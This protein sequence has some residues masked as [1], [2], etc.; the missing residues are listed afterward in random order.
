MP[1]RNVVSTLQDDGQEVMGPDV[2][3]YHHPGNDVQ[4][5]T[6]LTVESNHFCVL[7]SR[8][9]ARADDLL[10]RQRA[11]S[12]VGHAAEALR[13]LASG[14]RRRFVPD[15]T[16]EHP[17]PPADALAGLRATE[18]LR[19]EVGDMETRLHGQGFPASDRTW[20]RLRDEQVALEL[21]LAFDH[22]MITEADALEAACRTVSPDSLGPAPG[23]DPPALA[24]VRQRLRA[25]RD[26]VGERVA[27][28]LPPG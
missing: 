1:I 4:N 6:L 21:A 12:A 11:A 15:P 14:Y 27:H 8:E 3:L 2:L 17:L 25:L 22:R 24:P 10:I 23:M 19:G 16:H 26:T 5:G 7:K 13:D 20:A 18:A 28:M 9:Q